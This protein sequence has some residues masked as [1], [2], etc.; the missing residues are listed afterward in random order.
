MRAGICGPA[1]RTVLQALREDLGGN[2]GQTKTGDLCWETDNATWPPPRRRGSWSRPARSLWRPEKDDGTR[3]EHVTGATNGDNDGEYWRVTTTDGTRYYF[4]LNRLPGWTAG[5]AVTESA[6]TVP[7][8]GNDTGEP[9]H[10]ATFAAAACT[11]AY[12][13]NLDYVVDVHG[14]SMSYFYARETNKYGQNLGKTTD[15]HPRR[16]AER[17]ALR[18]PDR[19]GLRCRSGPGRP[20]A[21]T[22]A[23]PA[24]PAPSTT[25]PPGRM[26]PGTWTARG[27]VH[28]AQYVAVVLDH[29]TS[30]QGHHADPRRGR[31]LPSRG[32]VE[33]GTPSRG[34]VTGPTRASG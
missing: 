26:C 11:Q 22:A 32:P 28:D 5:K 9:C 25:P 14:N 1:S 2:N 6:W 17:G 31:Q 34:P 29:Q 18:H 7:V 15:L 8:Y 16:N 12:R 33:P 13:W 19:P 30:Y 23:C 21:P 4:G 27:D 20:H 10:A 24:R 3:V